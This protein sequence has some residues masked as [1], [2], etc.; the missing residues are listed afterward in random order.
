[1]AENAPLPGDEEPDD[2]DESFGA[3]EVSR[4]EA[5]SVMAHIKRQEAEFDAAGPTMA[6][7]LDRMHSLDWGSVDSDDMVRDIRDWRDRE[8]G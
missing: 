6:E 3:A 1:M 8:A 7:W 2:G 5:M 4:P